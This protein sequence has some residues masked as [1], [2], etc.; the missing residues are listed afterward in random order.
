MKIEVVSVAALS[1]GAEMVVTLS[2]SSEYGMS[3]KRKFLLFTEQ[4]LNLG[5]RKGMV[6]DE[7]TFDKIEELSKTCRA[8]RKGTDLLSYSSSS[9]ARLVGRLRSKGIDKESATSAAEHLEK[10][11]LID[12]E[13]D[14]ER[15]VASCLKK[16]WGRKRIFQELCAKGYEKSVVENEVSKLDEDLMVKNCAELLKKKHRVIPNDPDVIK[17]IVAS[18]VRYGYTYSEIKQAFKLIEE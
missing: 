18:L 15:Q 3:E 7:E 10:I 11:G 6:I 8:I 16:L 2:V 17:K 14:V 1:E 5:I 9:K 13:L 12:E 4:Y